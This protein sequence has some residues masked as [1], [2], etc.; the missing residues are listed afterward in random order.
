MHNLPEYAKFA[1]EEKDA[2]ARTAKKLVDF[3]K[4][5]RDAS[6]AAVTPVKHVI[7]VEVK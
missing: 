4:V 5:A 7:K 6:A 3:D 1:P 2:F